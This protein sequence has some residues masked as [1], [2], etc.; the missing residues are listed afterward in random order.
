MAWSWGG[1]LWDAVGPLSPEVC[2]DTPRFWEQGTALGG[3]AQCSAAAHAHTTPHGFVSSKHLPL[4]PHQSWW[5]GQQQK[6][7]IGALGLPHTDALQP[8]C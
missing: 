4:A 7:L 1:N 2:G 6:G 3:R 5:P 8:F